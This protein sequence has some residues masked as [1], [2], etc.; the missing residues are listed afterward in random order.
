MEKE[1]KRNCK[2]IQSEKAGKTQT[3][4]KLSDKIKPESV[5]DTLNT[6]KKKT[7]TKTKIS[8][9]KIQ[10]F[11]TADGPG[12]RTTVFFQ[13][14]N[15]RCKWCH[16]PETQS[17]KSTFLTFCD[18]RKEISG[19]TMSAEEVFSIIKKDVDFYE[20]SEGG[21]TLSGGEPLLQADAA[22]K[23]LSLCKQEN[24]STIV[25]TAGA[26]PFENFLKVLPVTDL[27]YFDIKAS[28]SKK[29]LSFTGGDFS[30]IRENLIRLTKTGARVEVCVPLILGVNTD[31][32]SR[33]KIANLLKTAGINDIILLP[34]HKYGIS[35]YKAL[36]RNYEFERKKLTPSPVIEK[37]KEFYRQKG[38]TL[39][40]RK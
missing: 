21:V 1:I 38:F 40:T 2:K 22:K 16:N 36:G 6:S 34:Y 27:F 30:L 20:I 10:R 8:I 18:E 35:K 17:T 3:E 31:A 19:K 26:V 33:N 29:Y 11:S 37:T 14:C 32:S 13:G 15:L 7:T 4:T 9:S 39:K 12:I 5:T 28:D 23:L 25:D 24:I